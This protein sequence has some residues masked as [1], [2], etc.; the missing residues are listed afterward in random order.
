MSMRRS[1]KRRVLRANP[2]GVPTVSRRAA[3]V[4]EGARSKVRQDAAT[5]KLKLSELRR[6]SRA[7]VKRAVGHD[8]GDV[9][10]RGAWQQGDDSLAVDEYVAKRKDK[11]P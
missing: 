1:I 9:A 8:V 5:K 3:L 4:I 10:E 11:P 6:K 7:M 2:G